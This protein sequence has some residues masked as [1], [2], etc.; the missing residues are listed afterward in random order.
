MKVILLPLAQ[1]D[2]QEIKK[3]LSQK[4]P[5]AS[6]NVAGKIKKSLQLLREQPYIGHATENEHIFE[7]HIPQTPYTLPY[8]IMGDYVQILHVFHQ[9]QQKP[10]QWS[11]H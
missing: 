3:Y 9:S 2:L 5:Q 10:E 1:K 8:R 6:K 7:W 11:L 4:S